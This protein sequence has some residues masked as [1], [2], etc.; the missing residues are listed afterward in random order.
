MDGK[1][2]FIDCCNE[3]GI[4]CDELFKVGRGDRGGKTRFEYY[5]EPHSR[6]KSQMYAVKYFENEDLYLAWSLSVPKAKGKKNFS[7]ARSKVERFG[8]NEIKE[9][10]KFIEYAGR[11]EEVVFIFRA[12]GVKEFLSKT[13]ETV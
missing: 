10:N 3:Q 2:Y 9:A 11:E 12:S 5:C 4:D 8:F 13:I 1:Q 7:L 6:K